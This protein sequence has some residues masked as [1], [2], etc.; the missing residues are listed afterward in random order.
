MADKY[1]EQRKSNLTPTYCLEKIKIKIVH[2][3]I[4]K[5]MFLAVWSDWGL[6]QPTAVSTPAGC[7]AAPSKANHPC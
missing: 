3:I 6:Q 1:A 4:T 7:T 2:F 5:L